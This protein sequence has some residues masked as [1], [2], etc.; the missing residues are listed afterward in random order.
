VFEGSVR[1][2]GVGGGGVAVEVVERGGV[3][4]EEAWGE[5]VF[6][7]LARRFGWEVGA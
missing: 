4:A 3:A 2:C 5:R 7:K 1:E 6:Y